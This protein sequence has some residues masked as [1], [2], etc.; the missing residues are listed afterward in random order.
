VVPSFITALMAGESPVIFGDGEQSRDFTYV[1]NV[2]QAN[3]LAMNAPGV[4]GNVYNVACGE[5]V[6]LN[7]LVAQLRDLLGTN[8]E[9]V[10]REGRPGDVRHSLADIS[11]ARRDLGYEPTVLLRAGLERTIAHLTAGEELPVG[12]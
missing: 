3:V 1:A 8:V 9:P 12:V 2:V 4:V 11:A 10:Y 7:A 6:T 5:N